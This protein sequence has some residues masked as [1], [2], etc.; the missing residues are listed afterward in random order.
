[1]DG[2]LRDP[3]RSPPMPSRPKPPRPKN[4]VRKIDIDGIVFESTYEA[5]RYEKLKLMMASGEIATFILRVPFYLAG[6]IKY[7]ADFVVLYP[8]GRYEVE[9]AKIPT[10]NGDKLYLIKKKRVK[11]L[12]GIEIKEV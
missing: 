6:G 12:Y 11:E 2:L 7:I 3:K 4:Q 1:M 8:Y 10:S 9:T 5:E